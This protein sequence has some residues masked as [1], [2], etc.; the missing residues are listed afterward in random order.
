MSIKVIVVA[1]L[2]LIILIVLLMIMGGKTK[3]FSKSV[4][5]CEQK[6][7]GAECIPE[8]E[9]DDCDGPVHRMGTDCKERADNGDARGPWCCVPIG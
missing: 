9:A 7:P 1:V 2:C 3:L 4:V 5:S 6:G 8:S